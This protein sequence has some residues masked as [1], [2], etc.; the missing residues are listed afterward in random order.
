M[1]REEHVEKVVNYPRL[2]GNFRKQGGVEEEKNETVRVLVRNMVD[3][4][5]IL[6][7]NG[8]GVASHQK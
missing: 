1:A 7:L 3:S 6:L 2:F 4:S 5:N 8:E